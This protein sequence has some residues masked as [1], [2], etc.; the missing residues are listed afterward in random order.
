[1]MVLGQTNKQQN[2]KRTNI[3]SLCIYFTG[4]SVCSIVVH[5]YF[6]FEAF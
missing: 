2:E 1:M 5:I 3:P 6:L 4:D